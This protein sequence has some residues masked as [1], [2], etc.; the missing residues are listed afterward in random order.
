MGNHNYL[1][2]TVHKKFYKN[3]NVN[4][5]TVIGENNMVEYNVSNT[6]KDV[7]TTFKSYLQSTLF[8]SIL[9]LKHFKLLK[10]LNSAP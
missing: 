5:F 10:L 8:N 7:L 2:T 9:I 4:K 6:W 1:A 3:K